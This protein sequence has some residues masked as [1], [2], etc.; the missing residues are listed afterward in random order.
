MREQI[1]LSISNFSQDESI[2]VG[3]LRKINEEK[4]RQM[5]FEEVSNLFDGF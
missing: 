3:D 5:S 1:R 2:I 4:K